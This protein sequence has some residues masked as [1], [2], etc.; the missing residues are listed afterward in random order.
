M[1]LELTRVL[2]WVVA[3]IVIA[4]L[5]RRLRHRGDIGSGSGGADNGGGTDEQRQYGIGVGGGDL[6][7]NNDGEE[8]RGRGINK[9]TPSSTA[10][11]P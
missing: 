10:T 8:V 4:A 2:G 9:P 7:I 11:F 1:L 3:D 5:A 6:P